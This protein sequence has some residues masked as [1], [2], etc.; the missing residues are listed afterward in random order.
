MKEI[1]RHF[2][3]VV[4]VIYL[5]FILSLAVLLLVIISIPRLLPFNAVKKYITALS[6]EF[7]NA[8]VWFLKVTLGFIHRPKWSDEDPDNISTKNWY[9]GMSNHM[10][11]ADIFVLLFTSNYKIP[12]LKFFMKKELKWIP[13]IYL[14]HKTIDMPFLNRHKAS[15]I[16]SNPSLKSLDFENARVAAKRFTRYPTTAFSFVEGTRF[17]EIKKE[18]QSSPYDDLLKPKVGALATAL[19]GMPMVEELI[20][21]T[22][23]YKTPRRSAW[24]FAC[25]E[26]REAKIII[27][28]YKIPTFIRDTDDIGSAKF[29]SEFKLFIDDIWS[30][31]QKLISEVKF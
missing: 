27:R 28:A 7:G 31:K 22:I 20:D 6:N 23:I 14:V 13:I 24:D 17:S 5:I 25:G 19:S 15:E 10:S 11:W 18:A 29:R 21:F 9:I 8:I 26:M 1:L 30:K 4:S 16:R 3:G 2:T 12:L